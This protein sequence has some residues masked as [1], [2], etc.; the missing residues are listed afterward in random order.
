MPRG[1]R[2]GPAGMGPMTG[3]ARGYCAGFD[4]PGFAN[5]VG[6]GYGFFGGGRGW[7]HWFYATGLPRWA[8]AGWVPPAPAP[9]Q[10]A[11]FLKSQADNLRKAA[12]SIE[13]RLEELS[14]GDS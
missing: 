2:T 6:R 8:R 1:D 12:E 14:R 9:E 7:R 3:G 5:P 10:E 4:V 13:R 11:G